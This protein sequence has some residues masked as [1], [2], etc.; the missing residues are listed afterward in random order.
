MSS[1][2]SKHQ[3]TA[4]N[5]LISR[6]EESGIKQVFVLGSTHQQLTEHQ[7]IKQSSVVTGIFI[8]RTHV[9]SVDTADSRSCC[10]NFHSAQREACHWYCY[11]Y[12]SRESVTW[13]VCLPEKHIFNGS[14]S[15]FDHSTGLPTKSGSGTSHDILL[16]PHAVSVPVTVSG[17]H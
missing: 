3:Q 15:G 14:P 12:R 9:D 7:A 16:H 4:V 11:L 8:P 13:L 17:L 1:Q 10:R 6:N 2:V 5:K